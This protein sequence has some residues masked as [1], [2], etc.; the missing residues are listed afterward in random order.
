MET[1]PDKG[2]FDTLAENAPI[3]IFYSGPDGIVQYVNKALAIAS[4]Y[5][6]EALVGELW[7]SKIHPEDRDGVIQRW[8]ENVNSL[9]PWTDEFR[10][11][12]RDGTVAWAEGHTNP[13]IDDRGKVVSHV[14][15]IADITTRKQSEIELRRARDEL[16]LRIE[17]RTREFNEEVY[18]R[19]LAE[20]RL[21]KNNVQIRAPDR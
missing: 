20:D 13:Q 14:G 12:R 6:A 17:D 4:G 15:T 7:S 19:K 3:G 18:E 21:R 2:L 10:F 1:N 9:E 5:P 11:I 16:E 8:L